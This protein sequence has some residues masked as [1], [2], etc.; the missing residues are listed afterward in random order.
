MFDFKAK[1]VNSFLQL[2]KTIG[3][4]LATIGLAGA[5][6]AKRFSL[7]L[8]YG[9]II[10]LFLTLLCYISPSFCLVFMIVSTSFMLIICFPFRIT[11]T[12]TKK[13][14]FLINLF[15]ELLN[16]YNILNLCAT[17]YI[18]I[19]SLEPRK[20]KLYVSCLFIPIFFYPIISRY[21]YITI[22][23]QH[24][25]ISFLTYL[26]ISITLFTGLF[27]IYLRLILSFSV[28][29]TN[30]AYVN[31]PTLLNPNILYVLDPND[32]ELPSSVSNNHNKSLF[33]FDK[34]KHTNYN[35]YIFPNST[36][37]KRLGI[38][39]AVAGTCIAFYAALQTGQQTELLRLQVE[40]ERLSLQQETRMN[41]LEE[42]SQGLMTKEAYNKKW[43]QVIDVEG[44]SND[45]SFEDYKKL[46]NSQKAILAQQ[47]REARNKE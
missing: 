25:S 34:S 37:L 33:H 32:Q 1:L 27:F 46:S 14:L 7:M 29:V 4:G 36:F 35:T 26:F 24:Q 16:H 6:I 28:L 47:S 9:L 12:F 10:T 30:L 20:F 3:A 22:I 5:G 19:F 11:D 15:L 43:P 40:Q 42:V 39:T 2:G 17:L 31:K 23:V 18:N 45:L 41:D 44:N 38:C 8:G 21:Y 13:R